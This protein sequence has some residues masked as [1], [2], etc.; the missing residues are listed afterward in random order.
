MEAATHHSEFITSGNRIL[1][2]IKKQ[3]R[4]Y[5]VVFLLFDEA[6]LGSNIY[7]DVSLRQ[8]IHES[9][10]PRLLNVII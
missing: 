2:Y 8:K 1:L 10:V 4:N 5:L 3:K 7:R 9:H 6:S